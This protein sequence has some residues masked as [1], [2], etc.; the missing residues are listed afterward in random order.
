MG[1]LIDGSWHDKWYDTASSKGR[2]E[3]SE[4]QFRNWVTKDGSAGPSGKSGFKAEK[5]RY[6]LYVSLACPWA[7]RTLIFRNIKGLQ[8]AISI[9]VVHWYMAESGWTFNEAEG[10]IQDP[11]NNAKNYYEIYLAADPN[12]SGR[13]TVPIL[14]DKHENTI[15]S[16]ESSE[17][18]RMLNSEFDHLGAKK[19]DYYPETLR[20]EI[21]EINERI[22]HTINNGVYKC[23]FATTQEAYEE[24]LFPLF[25]TLD[26]IEE[27]LA[28]NRYLLG[29]QITEAD[30]RLFTTLI[31][32]DSVYYSHFK[33]NLKHLSDYPNL[34]GYTRELYQIPGVAET[35]DMAH[36]K[37]HYFASH[38]SI[39][40]T[41][42]VPV[43]PDLNF[44]LP[45]N[46][47]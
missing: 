4:A 24:S 2:F 1:L 32:F 17:I 16:N 10:V 14:W 5:D 40:P 44:E 36:I 35:I 19:G 6:H 33:C 8:D 37:N 9:S 18:I 46:R 12:Y 7:N 3:R 26:W 29:N 27:R 13:V 21:D 20:K 39:N 34:W 15:V 38:K 28:T 43:G 47:E 22:Y 41:G 42:I 45:H 11:I 31:R 25:E 23:G 30:W